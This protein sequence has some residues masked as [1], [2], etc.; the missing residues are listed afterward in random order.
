MLNR[1]FPKSFDNTFR[2]HWL[3]LWLLVPIVLIKALQGANSI[4][5]TRSTAINADGIPLDSFPPVAAETV[6]SMFAL[7]GFYLLLVPLQCFVVLLRYRSMIPVMYLML[8]VTQLGARTVLFFEPAPRSTSLPV[9]LLINLGI[10]AVTLI[11]FALS[12]MGRPQPS[13]KAS[14]APG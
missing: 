8:L 11:G 3:S 13:S 7:L 5:L 1:I 14:P 6:L 2:G 10:V 12:L 4:V 9:G